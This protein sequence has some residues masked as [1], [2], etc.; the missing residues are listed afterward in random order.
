MT[1]T[2]IP[3]TNTMKIFGTQTDGKLVVGAEYQDI[4]KDMGIENVIIAEGVT[5]I[6]ERA[7]LRVQ[8]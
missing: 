3:S 4:I 1:Y 2:I 7:F 5:A 8:A 6:D